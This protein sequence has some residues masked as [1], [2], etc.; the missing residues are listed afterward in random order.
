MKERRQKIRKRPPPDSDIDSDDDDD[1]NSISEQE[2]KGDNDNNALSLCEKARALWLQH[3]T[4][5]ED[6]DA[7]EDL[8]RRALNA[9]RK[10]PANAKNNN[11]QNSKMNKRKRSQNGVTTVKTVAALTPE[12]YRTAGERLSLM[13]LQSGRP[14][15]ATMGLKYLGFECRLSERILNYP[16]GAVISS[17]SNNNNNPTKSKHKKNKKK[18]HNDNNN[19]HH[20]SS[21]P[22]PPCCVVDDFLSPIELG[23]LQM[24]FGDVNSSYWTSHNYIIDKEPPAPYF[25][26]VIDLKQRNINLQQQHNTNRSNNGKNKRQHQPFLRGI[27]DKILRQGDVAA[28]FPSLRRDARY[29]ELWA[30]NRPHASGHQLHFDSDDEGR[31]RQQGGFPNHPI[32]STVLNV[33]SHSR[34]GGPTLV[35]NQRLRNPE[36][37]HLKSVRGW[38]VPSTPSR[39]VCFDGSVLHGVIPGKGVIPQTQSTAPGAPMPRRVTLMMAFWKDIRVRKGSGPGSARPWPSPKASLD[40]KLPDWANELNRSDVFLEGSSLSVSSQT[41]T[42][43]TSIQNQPRAQIIPVPRVYELLDGTPVPKYHDDESSGGEGY[44]MPEYDKVF[45]GF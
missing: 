35:T 10:V 8:Y 24:V 17:H 25:S 32:C 27:V 20:D 28:R 16:A 21:L 9:K 44:Y 23:H 4:E 31:S 43:R 3:A 30:H 22:Q 42:E 19:N 2:K 12:E 15:K 37:T 40:V 7:V 45:Q 39:L 18:H 38:L 33:S 13:Y 26:Y 11:T 6:L 14:Y 1:S 29:V 41:D 36:T 5:R 34:V